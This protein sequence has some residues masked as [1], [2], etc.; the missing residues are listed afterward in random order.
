MKIF[1]AENLKYLRKVNGFTQESLAMYMNKKHST[2][3]NWE[4][5]N[6]KPNIEELSTLAT[7]FKIDVNTILFKDLSDTSHLS[8]MLQEQKPESRNH[9]NGD[10]VESRSYMAKL[11]ESLEMNIQTLQQV[12]AAKTSELESYKQKTAVI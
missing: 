12:V 3:G 1:F 2:I 10:D 6:S 7:Y 8:G 5:R 4:K 9:L 11:I